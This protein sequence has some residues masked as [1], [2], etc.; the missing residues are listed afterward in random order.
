MTIIQ[1][2]CSHSVGPGTKLFFLVQITNFRLEKK[3]FS[4]MT[5]VFC[6][7]LKYFGPVKGQYISY[8]QIPYASHYNPRFV[9]FYLIFHCGSYSRAVYIAEW[10]VLQ[11][12]F[13][14]PIHLIHLMLKKKCRKVGTSV[15]PTF[16]AT[17]KQN[18]P[19]QRD[20]M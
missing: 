18:I 13:S 17:K 8:F 19:Y 9:F 20:V 7:Y 15:Y 14:E 12:N 1:Q 16:Y 2:I 4:T 6:P 3:D 11:G 5:F 10:L